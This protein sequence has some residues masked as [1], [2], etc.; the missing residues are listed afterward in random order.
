MKHNQK[1]QKLP[2]ETEND[3]GLAE[4]FHQGKQDR[5]SRRQL[6]FQKKN[7]Y[8]YESERDYDS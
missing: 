6:K 5:A 3:D 7:R 1:F 8:D 2:R 4:D